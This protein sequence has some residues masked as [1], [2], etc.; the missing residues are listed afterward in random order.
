MSAKTGS[1]RAPGLA[2]VERLEDWLADHLWLWLL[3][4]AVLTR[5]PGLTTRP[6]WYDE[7]FAVLFSA[8][9]PPAMLYGTL[10]VE[11][12]VAADVHPLLYYSLLWLWQGAFG[13]SPLSVRALS[14]VFGLAVVVLGV[15][16]ARWLFDERVALWAGLLLALSPFQVHYSQE[17]RMYSLLAFWLLSATA[18]LWRALHGGSLRHWA[19]LALSAAAA[20]YTH[21]LAFC[22]LLPL[23][24]IALIRG[25]WRGAL[26][27][28]LAGTGAVV[29]YLP[30]LVRLPFQAARVAQG[31]WIPSPG[32]ADLVRTLVVFVA[33]RPV[34]QQV[35]PI[36][37]AATVLSGAAIALALV[38]GRRSAPGAVAAA[39]SAAPVGVMFAISQ[40][41]PVYL[42]RAMLAAG[43][44]FLICLAWALRRG[45]LSP[46][47]RVLAGAFLAAAT[48][49]GLWGTYTYRGFP[50]APFAEMGAHLRAQVTAGERVIH[51]NKI[52]ALPS[53]Y[54]APDVSQQYLADLPG[55][56]SD[57]LARATQ[58]V[59]GL[60]ADADIASAAG[61]APGVWFVAFTRELEEYRRMGYDVHPAIEWLTSRYRLGAAV[62]FG[63]VRLY[64][65]SAREVE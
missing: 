57:T 54:Y 62:V 28:L 16:L 18:L 42:D 7:A 47:L 43:A 23:A 60:V 38:R 10:A 8:K 29:L 20:Q 53:V 37:I 12:G 52:T 5:L 6:L 25:G 48:A 21:N 3:P 30:W 34:E 64:H 50:H 2:C 65:F 24:L 61:D 9:G 63:E 49:L 39:L 22:Y 27:M 46:A 41:R 17:A 58:E 35:L 19:G 32:L 15:L 4:L 1:F 40:W 44:M 56:G 51:S 11:G 13:A 31:Y 14:L 36:L 33:S 55:S 26:R 45:L 59:L